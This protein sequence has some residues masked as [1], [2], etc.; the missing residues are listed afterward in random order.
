M[1]R[2]KSHSGGAATMLQKHRR[3]TVSLLLACAAQKDLSSSVESEN[4]ISYAHCHSNNLGDSVAHSIPLHKSSGII[5][6]LG[7]SFQI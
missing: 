3:I 1:M 5:E 7:Q 2:D 6:A 4:P